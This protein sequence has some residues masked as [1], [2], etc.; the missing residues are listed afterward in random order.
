M[1]EEERNH[2]EK[3]S[4]QKDTMDEVKHMQH[5]N[6]EEDYLSDLEDY[7]DGEDPEEI[8]SFSPPSFAF[9]EH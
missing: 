3:V 4:N 9:Q 7:F 1:F 2:G 5:D 8:T 6:K